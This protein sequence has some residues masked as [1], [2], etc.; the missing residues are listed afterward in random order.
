VRL[1]LTIASAL[2]AV[3]SGQALHAGEAQSFGLRSTTG[4]AQLMLPSSCR[5][6]LPCC[7][8]RSTRRRSSGVIVIGWCLPGASLLLIRATVSRGPKRGLALS[9]GRYT[10]LNLPP[11]GRV[12]QFYL[13]RAGIDANRRTLPPEKDPVRSNLSP[14]KPLRKRNLQ[15]PAFASWHNSMPACAWRNARSWFACGFHQGGSRLVGS[16]GSRTVF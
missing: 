12:L 14:S 1:T 9:I 15:N 3:L 10:D 11:V 8:C 5:C 7:A 6:P 13:E 16:D 4:A 2:I